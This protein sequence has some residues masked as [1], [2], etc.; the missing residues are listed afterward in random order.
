MN[1]HARSM[2]SSGI[3]QAFVAFASNLIMVRYLSPS[4]FGIFA[5]ILANAS[6]LASFFNLRIN[7]L[8]LRSS[9][10]ELDKNIGTYLN[11]VLFQIVLLFIG[12]IILTYISG[13]LTTKAW[14]IIIAISISPYIQLKLVLFEKKMR[15]E[16]IAILE[17]S[18]LFLS[19]LLAAIG[20][21]A[22][23][24]AIVL[25]LRVL[26]QPIFLFIGLSTHQV[27]IKNSKLGFRFNDLKSIWGKSKWIYTDNILEQGLERL[28]II[29]ANIIAGTSAVGFFFQAKRLSVTP[30]QL[31]QPFTT[32]VLLNHFSKIEG[33]NKKKLLNKVLKFEVLILTIA[34]IIIYFFGRQI[35]II[36]FGEEWSEVYPIIVNLL[37]VVALLTIFNS[38]KA[39]FIANKDMKAFT[40]WARLPLVFTLV[41][42]YYIITLLDTDLSNIRILA[43]SISGAYFI[44]VCSILIK[45]LNYKS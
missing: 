11:Y 3:F 43:T 45:Y 12:G 7:D 30:H 32:R 29:F 42:L 17:S 8:I 38:F 34:V 23:F 9:E 41:A 20:V 28:T 27:S 13:Y 33:C 24:G 35:I 10:A 39:Y 25:Y 15:Y 44:A 18:S 16:R 5:I 22:G 4:D 26:I 14:L 19:H 21:I 31:L 37:G 1:S 36:L 2:I 6:I 40:F